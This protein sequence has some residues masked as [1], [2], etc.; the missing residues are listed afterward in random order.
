MRKKDRYILEAAEDVEKEFHVTHLIKQLRTMEGI[1]R[2]KLTDEEWKAAR[3]KYSLKRLDQD[4][5]DSVKEE[6][7]NEVPSESDREEEMI[8]IKNDALISAQAAPS[9]QNNQVLPDDQ[10][11]AIVP[12]DEEEKGSV[13]STAMNVQNNDYRTRKQSISGAPGG[14]V[15]PLN[16]HEDSSNL[17]INPTSDRGPS[18]S[19]KNQPQ[20]SFL[21]PIGK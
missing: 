1:L 6:F 2:E 10:R 9:A 19:K 7:V 4:L 15:E 13:S 5:I 8:A 21:P 3:A 14:D 16:N 20:T 18:Q 17:L 11:N 12:N